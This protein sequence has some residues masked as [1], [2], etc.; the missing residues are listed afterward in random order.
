MSR[1]A[2]RSPRWK[3]PSRKISISSF[4]LQAVR[5]L[6]ALKIGL[7]IPL[8]YSGWAGGSIKSKELTQAVDK[9]VSF[10]LHSAL[11]A[12]R[13]AALKLSPG[14][15]LVLTGAAAAL[16]P[17]KGM[18]AYGV[19]KGRNQVSSP[20][21]TRSQILLPAATHHLTKSMAQELQAPSSALAILPVTID[22]PGNRAGM[23]NADTSTWTPVDFIAKTVLGWIEPGARP[24]SG[25]LV[26]VLTEAGQSRLETAH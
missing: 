8:N 2:F 13:I 19:T 20:C 26:K 9:M 23:P 10:N 3:K 4:A 15:L 22:T 11:Q 5:L 17:T 25:S 18:I 12:S 21:S 1:G 16:E 24:P 7:F 6:F 14:G